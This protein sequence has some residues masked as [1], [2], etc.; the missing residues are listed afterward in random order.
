MFSTLLLKDK[1]LLK[2]IAFSYM[3]FI[4]LLP[5][6]SG[7]CPWTLSIS[8]L[9]SSMVISLISVCCTS[10]SLKLS[11]LA[12][13]MVPVSSRFHGCAKAVW[14]FPKKKLPETVCTM[15]QSLKH[16]W[17]FCSLHLPLCF[18]VVLFPSTWKS[19]IVLQNWFVLLKL[20][21]Q[22]LLCLPWE[23]LPLDPFVHLKVGSFP[24]PLDARCCAPLCRPNIWSPKIFCICRY[25]LYDLLHYLLV[26]RY[27]TNYYYKFI[28]FK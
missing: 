9:M 15:Q 13:L 20:L 23:V 2:P 26:H 3:R 16:I 21:A 1:W 19:L 8:S 6:F 4:I 18:I 22:D 25:N 10:S 14:S 27:T 7:R 28:V 11:K 12:I 5:F 17:V 24:I